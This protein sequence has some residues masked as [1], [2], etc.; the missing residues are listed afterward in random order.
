[1]LSGR[2]ELGHEGVVRSTIETGIEPA[3]DPTLRSGPARHHRV[4]RAVHR[5]G[6]ARIPLVSAEIGRLGQIGIDVQRDSR[7]VVARVGEPVCVGVDQLER[8]VTL[9][10]DAPGRDDIIT[11]TVKALNGLLMVNGLPSIA[12]RI[13]VI[14][15]PCSD[16]GITGERMRR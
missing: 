3:R 5:N 8:P 4:S 6:I 10:V 9:V 11:E 7:I 12:S 15:D 16:R 1:M 2:A 14:A 13:L